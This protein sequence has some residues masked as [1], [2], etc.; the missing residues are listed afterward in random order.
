MD[1]YAKSSFGGVSH[2]I[3]QWSVK[4]T[5]GDKG[6]GQQWLSECN[7]VITWIYVKFVIRLVGFFSIYLRKIPQVDILYYKF[8]ICTCKMNA[9]YREGQL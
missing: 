8:K 9:I 6:L 4:A 7:Q 1:T 2:R 5:C 3:N